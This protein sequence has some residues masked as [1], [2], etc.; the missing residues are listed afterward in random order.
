M[1]N[2]CIWLIA[3]YAMLFYNR[4]LKNVLSLFYEPNFFEFSKMYKV[5]GWDATDVQT[6]EDL[7]EIFISVDS[8]WVFNGKS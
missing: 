3:R 2:K 1:M 4:L 5:V 7:M 6:N 8:N